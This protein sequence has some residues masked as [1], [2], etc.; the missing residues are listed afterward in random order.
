MELAKAGAPA[1]H[2]HRL[3]VLF[4]FVSS[5]LPPQSKASII[6]IIAGCKRLNVEV[7]EGREKKEEMWTASL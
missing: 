4:S 7:E 6:S 5:R 1:T 3:V 2:C